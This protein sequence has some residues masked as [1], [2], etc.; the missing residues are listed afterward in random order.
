MLRQKIKPALL[1]QLSL[2]EIMTIIENIT[3][4]VTS[5]FVC[6]RLLAMLLFLSGIQLF[7]FYLLADMIMRTNLES[8]KRPIYTVRKM[9]GRA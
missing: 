7:S 5:I 1:R 3:L 2:S 4:R 6:P 9:L 8:Q